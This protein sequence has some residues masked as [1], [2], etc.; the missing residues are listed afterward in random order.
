MKIIY[1]ILTLVLITGFSSCSKIVNFDLNESDEEILV[2]E[3]SIS[4]VMKEHEVML[5]LSGRFYGTE[6][7]P[8]AEGA[9]V[10]ISDG[11]T[12]YS[13][14]EKEPGIY[15]TDSIQG[16]FGKTYTLE[17]AYA[18]QIYVATTNLIEVSILDSIY[19]GPSIIPGK[20]EE[21]YSIWVI[22]TELAGKGDFYR[23][24][25]YKNDVSLTDTLG[26][27]QFGND[28][29][30]DGQELDLIL[31]PDLEGELGDIIRVEQVSISEEAYDIY[32]SANLETVWRGSIF[33]SPP[34]NVP[35]NI[36][37][38]ALGLF[39]AN[40]VSSAETTILF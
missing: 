12:K 19:I 29:F 26:Q 18:S 11:T 21:W 31:T 35:S 23:W 27:Y 6:A 14:I 30:V 24:N 20:E 7:L 38:G 17:I 15:K 25:I 9:I 10:S 37:N 2:V 13:L 28:E 1:F 33:D 3:G 4:N 39:E 5:S 40:G 32:L 36:S 22:T 16:E 34:A 8:M